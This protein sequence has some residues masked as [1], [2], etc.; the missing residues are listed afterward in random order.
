MWH[1]RLGHMSEKWLRILVRKL[2]IPSTK[3]EVLDL[4]DY[5]PFGKQHNV[6]FNQTSKWKHNVLYLVYYDVCGP[7]E[8]ESLGG[9]RYFLTFIDDASR[10][11]EQHH[12]EEPEEPPLRRSKRE[13]QPSKRYHSSEYIILT[14]EGETKC[15]QD[16][17]IHKDKAKWKNAMKDEIKLLQE[18]GTYELVELPKGR[19]EGVLLGGDGTK[20]VVGILPTSAD[21]VGEIWG[22]VSWKSKLQKCMALSTTEANYIAATEAENEQELVIKAASNGKEKE[23]DQS[24]E[25]IQEKSRTEELS[26]LQMEMNRMKEENKALKLAIEQSMNNFYDL[27]MKFDSVQ[28][29]NTQNNDPRIFFPAAAT[30]ELKTSSRVA[31]SNSPS[32]EEEDEKENDELGL[33]LG[34]ITHTL[35]QPRREEERLEHDTNHNNNNKEENKRFVSIQRGDHLAAAANIVAPPNRKTRVSVRA[36]CETA[37]MN[38]GCQW[39][40]Y[41]QKIAK[42]NPCPRAYY[43]C[44][45]A[46]GCP[47]RKQVQRCLEDM[48]ILITTYEGTHNHPLPVGATA[49]A[50]TTSAST[51]YVLLDSSNPISIDSMQNFSQS[52]FPYMNSPMISNP[53]TPYLNMRNINPSGNFV[54]A[55]QFHPNGTT[56]QAYPWAPTIVNAQNN[57][58]DNFFNS[59]KEVNEINASW[60][61]G[62]GTTSDNKALAENV[63]AIT[64]D[65]NFRV[66]VAAAI[67][68]LINKQTNQSSPENIPS[69]S[70]LVPKQGDEGGS[71]SDT[72]N[73]VLE[74]CPTG[75]PPVKHSQ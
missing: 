71:G 42:G 21:K 31:V 29:Q 35:S 39:R 75:V 53:M 10:K 55:Q 28:C 38:D 61:G 65:P 72:K 12:Q 34:M 22:A 57:V 37:T 73:W 19:K 48:S 64:S 13:Y 23:G 59:H 66:A 24:Q 69:G 30:D 63:S 46:P 67:S 56:H 52:S 5:C 60:R 8:D 43:R 16:A 68:S 6:S 40:K 26:E 51:P 25:A 58:R 32:R 20:D 17:Q 1:Q 36:R 4:C 9:N 14:E 27:K 15:F 54:E 49:M 70:S 44:T 7:F 33:S 62:E 18:M 11:G 47:V 50:S 41:G 3:D 45:V 2:H 74:S